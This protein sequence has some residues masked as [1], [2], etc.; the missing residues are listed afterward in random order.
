MH[1]LNLTGSMFGLLSVVIFIGA[2]V[3]VVF[4]EATHMRKSKPV[5]LAAGLIW[6]LIG[7]AYAMHGMSDEAHE[8]ATHIVEEYG[9]LFLFLLVAITY[10]N[11]MEERRVFD[12]LRAKLIGMGLSYRKLFWLTGVLAFFLSGI[13]DNLT[14]ALVMGAVVVA[15]GRSS[16]KFVTVGCV[17]IVVAA[18]AGGAFTPFGDITTLMVWQKGVIDFFEFFVIF[19]PSMV[20]WFVPALI[21]SFAVPAELPPPATDNARMKPGGRVVLILFLLTIVT[22]ISFKNFLHLPPAMGM[23]MGLGYMQIYSYF[24]TRKGK[25]LKDSE[26]VLDAFKLFE[27][28]EWDTLLF[29]FGI[30]FAV[31]GLGVL[32]YL[33]LLSTALYDGLGATAANMILGAMS[34]VVDNIPLMFAVLTMEPEMS[35]GQ[36]LLITL[37]CGVGGSLLSIGSAAGVALMGQARG[38]YTFSGHLKWSWAIALGYFASIGV[39]LVLNAHHFEVAANA[40]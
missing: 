23:M 36:W 31:G 14:T 25:R 5:M 34:A 26:L 11:T 19:I 30:I 18:N 40:F 15:V 38:H 20:N 16:A 3:L 1:E 39:H 28:V 9:E 13:F 2:Y 10:V 17:N 32:G 7:I 22:A 21:M 12:A 29:F 4:E 33:D 24:L 6:T 37:T 35:H 27:R 8:H